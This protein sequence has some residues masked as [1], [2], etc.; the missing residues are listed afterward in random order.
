MTEILLLLNLEFF[1]GILFLI[2]FFISPIDF[3]EF[4]SFFSFIIVCFLFLLLLLLSFFSFLFLYS[5]L[6]HHNLLIPT[7]TPFTLHPSPVLKC[8][9]PLSNNLFFPSPTLSPDLTFPSNSPLTCNQTTPP[10]WT[11]I[12]QKQSTIST[13]HNP[14]LLQSPTQVPFITAAEIYPNPQQDYKNSSPHTSFPIHPPHFPS[15]PLVPLY[16]TT[17]IF[18]ANI[19]IAKPPTPTVYRYYHQEIFYKTYKLLL[20]N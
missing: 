17:Q 20:G 18:I 10:S 15:L 5:Q 19:T 3:F 2:C 9:A 7:L 6:N 14:K 11:L 13:W 4:S 1:V 16:P 8:I 12:T